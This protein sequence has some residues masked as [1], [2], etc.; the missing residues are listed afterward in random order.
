MFVAVSAGLHALLNLS[1]SGAGGEVRN[2]RRRKSAHSP[3]VRFSR[4][5]PVGD[6]PS[7]CP[8]TSHP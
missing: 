1:H 3:S 5:G 4:S 2:K 6:G 7:L 8:S